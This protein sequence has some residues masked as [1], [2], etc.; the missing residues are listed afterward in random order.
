MTMTKQEIREREHIVIRKLNQRLPE[1]MRVVLYDLLTVP[2]DS[3]GNEIDS[4]AE[5]ETITQTDLHSRVMTTLYHGYTRDIT[6]M[7]GAIAVI[8][9]D[10]DGVPYEVMVINRTV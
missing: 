10:D 6:P 5:V 2:C 9:R 1:Q 4:A 8:T 7:N 3:N